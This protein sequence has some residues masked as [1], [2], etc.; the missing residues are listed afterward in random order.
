MCSSDLVELAYF[1]TWN[2]GLGFHSWLEY[3]ERRSG[4]SVREVSVEVNDKL[5]IR[6][7]LKEASEH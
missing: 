2:L 7:I 3:Y 5:T 4:Q 6:P 1:S